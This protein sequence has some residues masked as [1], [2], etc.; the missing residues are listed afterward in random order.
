MTQPRPPGLPDP[1]ARL[2]PDALID[3]LVG[4]DAFRSGVFVA[5]WK[6]RG[7]KDAALPCRAGTGDTCS[8]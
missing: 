3:A 5:T 2:G 1:M 4:S 8:R 6:S 7:T